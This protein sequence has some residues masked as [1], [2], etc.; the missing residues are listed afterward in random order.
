MGNIAALNKP[1]QNQ[2]GYLYIGAGFFGFMVYFLNMYPAVRW[3]SAIMPGS[4][5][6][7]R[8]NMTI[9]KMAPNVKGKENSQNYIVME[10][11]GDIGAYNRSNRSLTHYVENST[12]FLVFLVM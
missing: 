5:D 4:M 2:Y 7:L 1:D 8:A 3:K 11:D 10:D 6:N 12:Q 9:L